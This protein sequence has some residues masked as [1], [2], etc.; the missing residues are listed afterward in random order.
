MIYTVVENCRLHTKNLQDQTERTEKG[1]HTEHHIL[2]PSSAPCFIYLK[3]MY[4]LFLI[5]G[6][7]IM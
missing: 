6:Y 2:L 1:K 5:A 4:N 7:I 3:T